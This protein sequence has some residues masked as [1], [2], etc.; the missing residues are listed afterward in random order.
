MRVIRKKVKL[1]VSTL[2]SI[3]MKRK[4]RNKNLNNIKDVTFDGATQGYFVF[5]TTNGVTFFRAFI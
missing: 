2:R 5:Q 4:E 1:T 3:K